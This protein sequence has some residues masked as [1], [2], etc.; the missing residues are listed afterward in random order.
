[1]ADDMAMPLRS[2]TGTSSG[3]S[4]AGE[5][6]STMR[7]R[8][9]GRAKTFSDPPVPG[10]QRRSSILSEFSFDDVRSSTDDLLLPKADGINHAGDHESSNW[11]SAP[12]AFALLPA[13]GGMFFKNG[14]AVVTDVTLLGLAAIFLNWSVRLPWC[15]MPH[16]TALLYLC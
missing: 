11:H 9:L 8:P 5:S 3:R 6:G 4:A 12:L 14:S 2:A 13:V 1:M 16:L 7:I 10:I 15:V